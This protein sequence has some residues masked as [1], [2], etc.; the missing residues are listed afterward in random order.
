M[1][2]DA[3]KAFEN[4]CF[5]CRKEA[6]KH[7]ERLYSREGAADLLGVSVSSLAEYETGITA[8]TGP[9]SASSSCAASHMARSLTRP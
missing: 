3:R 7:D 6:A 9:S 1:G 8:T 2:R 4:P 5:K